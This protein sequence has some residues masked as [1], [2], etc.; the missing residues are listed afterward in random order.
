L[1]R[2][3]NFFKT[4]TRNF[5]CGFIIVYLS[6]FLVF[7]KNGIVSYIKNKNQLEA[8]NLKEFEVEKQRNELKNKVERMYPANLDKDLL[9]EQY[10]RATGEI[11]QNEVVHYY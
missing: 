10:R 4:A 9:D 2:F 8:I 11:K 6:Y 7:G 3:V 5:L 1:T